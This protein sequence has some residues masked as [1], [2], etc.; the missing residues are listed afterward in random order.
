MHHIL[1]IVSVL[2]IS[3][4]GFELSAVQQSGDDYPE[5]FYGGRPMLGIYMGRSGDDGGILVRRVIPGTAAAGMGLES[6]DVIVSINGTSIDNHRSLWTE[7]S[8]S[9]V[10][11][12]VH[13]EVRRNDDV[14]G[15]D[16]QY[17]KWPEKIPHWKPGSRWN[18]GGSSHGGRSGKNRGMLQRLFDALG[19]KQQAKGQNNAGDSGSATKPGPVSLAQILKA[20]KA[21]TPNDPLS[22]HF[23]LDVNSET[24]KLPKT[25]V[26]TVVPKDPGSKAPEFSMKVKCAVNL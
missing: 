13:V 24:M 4:F 12:D 11:Q 10:G 16:G 9:N 17:G 1:C 15:F 18:R 3:S 25:D 22:F 20:H 23:K 26:L 21:L 6:G 19:G 8:N 2:I 5:G 7:V 14:L